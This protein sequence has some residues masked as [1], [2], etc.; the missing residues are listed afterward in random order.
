MATFK[1][2]TKHGEKYYMF[3]VYLGKDKLTG[4]EIRTTRRGFKTK[5]EA[6]KALRQVQ[7]DFENGKFSNQLNS[8]KTFGELFNL[9][10]DNVY[11]HKVKEA[12]LSTAK[13]RYKLYLKNM[14]T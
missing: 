2:Y 9:W 14:R 3:Q 12:T 11:K 10:F 4:K 5:K 7:A 8:P 1:N 13:E 6:Q